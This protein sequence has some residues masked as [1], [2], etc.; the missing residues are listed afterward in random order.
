MKHTIDSFTPQKI[1]DN[2]R[3]FMIT[4]ITKL[5]KCCPIRPFSIPLVIRY[6]VTEL[7]GLVRHKQSSIW[8]EETKPKPTLIG[9]YNRRLIMYFTSI[10]REC[11]RSL[12]PS[13]SRIIIQCYPPSSDTFFIPEWL[14]KDVRSFFYY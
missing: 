12:R 7:G 2:Q 5:A 4:H 6:E 9:Q 1:F 13:V 8:I 3:L 11:M 10:G 14:P